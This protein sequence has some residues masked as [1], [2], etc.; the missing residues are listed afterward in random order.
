MKSLL[1]IAAAV[2]LQPLLR[3]VLISPLQGAD[4]ALVHEK[5]EFNERM[6]EQAELQDLQ[7]KRRLARRT[8]RSTKCVLA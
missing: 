2:W 8:L 4:A 3:P 1:T 5:Q 7:M 6:L